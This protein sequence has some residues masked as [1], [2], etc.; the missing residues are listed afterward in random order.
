ME[1]PVASFTKKRL[2]F[3]TL[4]KTRK[5]SASIALAIG[6]VIAVLSLLLVPGLIFSS[7]A[8]ERNPNIIFYTSRRSWL[9]RLELLRAKTFYHAKH[10][11]AC[12]GG[13]EVHKSLCRG[14]RL[15]A[16]A[17][18]ADDG[19]SH[20]SHFYPWKQGSNAGRT[21]AI[22]RRFPNHVENV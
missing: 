19:A 18:G 13:D 10:R 5:T 12:N 9:R 14:S 21:V 4:L 16:F 11:Q 17:I 2:P 6:A 8:Q 3:I 20:R 1:G 22:T 15:R 7:H